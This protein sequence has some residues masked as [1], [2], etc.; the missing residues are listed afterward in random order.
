MSTT[1]DRGIV[2]IIDDDAAVLDSV[3]WLLDGHDYEVAC[4]DSA[5]AFLAAYDPQRI[6]CLLVD[7]RM[8]GMSGLELQEHLCQSSSPPPLAFVTAHGDIPMAVESMKKGALDFIQK[9]FDE[10]Q[11]TTVVDRMFDIAQ[12]QYREQREA[13]KRH[14]LIGKLTDRE[15]QVLE[16][17][18]AGRLN[19][20]IASD[21][22]ISIKTVEAHRSNVM[23]KLGAKTVADLLRIAL[24]EQAD[25]I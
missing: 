18:V 16:E 20:Q 17:I 19:K 25:P 2:Y 3:R 9:P 12:A 11:L 13:Q 15:T 21:L 24:S 22:G 7:V 5:E 6:S 23:N 4:F 1:P 8:T 10:G 14:A